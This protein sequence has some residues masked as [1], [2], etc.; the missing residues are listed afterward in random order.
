MGEDVRLSA[1]PAPWELAGSGYILLYWFSREFCRTG[2]FI[3]EGLLSSFKGGLGTVMYVDYRS[4]NIGPYQELLFIPGRFDFSGKRFFSITRIYVST[5]ESVEGG[6]ANWGI[7]KGLASFEK[8]AEGDGVERITVRADGAPVA[9]LLFSA[10]RMSVPV[11]TALVPRGF[12]TLAHVKE[13]NTLLTTPESSGALAPARL[14]ECRI[15]RELFPPI[16][17]VRPL[18]AVH[19]PRFTMVFPRA[20]HL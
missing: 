15:N 2:G 8:T 4:S 3:P 5:R 16:D 20:K 6:R 10:R 12:R 17:E 1:Y 14:L 19:V 7:P 11:T 18:C 9:Q 13:G